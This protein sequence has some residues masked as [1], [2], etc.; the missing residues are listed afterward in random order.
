MFTTH[1]IAG[2]QN[3]RVN[4]TTR[5]FVTLLALLLAA[6]ASADDRGYRLAAGDRIS[7]NVFGEPDLS[8]EAK[9]GD[10]GRIAYPFIGEV[11]VGGRT[12]AEVE[13]Q[14]ATALKGDFLVDPKVSVAVVEYRPF[15]INGQV[16]NPG[17]FP[18]QPGM[19]VR[20]AIAL[21]GGLTERAS[22][23]GITL[24]PEGQRD[25][26]QGRSVGLDEAVGPGEIVTID[27]SFF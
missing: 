23:R 20:K 9:V 19:T 8:V 25:R 7:I 3:S 1:C 6:V 15:F 22:E 18:Y 17:S 12:P 13:Q 11:L 4:T 10:N 5:L 26:K 2:R 21:A 14:V 16:K 24:I 27:E